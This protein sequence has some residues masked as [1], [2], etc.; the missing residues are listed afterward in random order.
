LLGR[1]ELPW[2]IAEGT[3]MIPMPRDPSPSRS[4]SLR[5]VKPG[6]FSTP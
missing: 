1:I 6:V 4:A 5:S 3:D 2:L